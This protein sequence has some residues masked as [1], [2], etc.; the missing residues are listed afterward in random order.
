MSQIARAFCVLV[1]LVGFAQAKP[2][3]TF[4]A[5]SYTPPKGWKTAVKKGTLT[6]QKIDQGKGTFAMILVPPIG[7]SRG[8]LA[9]DFRT[10]WDSIITA[11]FNVTDAPTMTPGTPE[12]GWEAL[13]GSAKGS[14]EG[15]AAMIVLV[16]MTGGGRTMNIVIAMNSDTYAAGVQ[17]FLESVEMKKVSAPAT[18]APATSTPPPAQGTGAPTTTFD[19]GWT[20][21][22]EAN[23]VR[24]TREGATVFLHYPVPMDDASRRDTSAYYWNQLVAPRYAVT[25]TYAQDSTSTGLPVYFIQGDATDRATGKQ[26]FVSLRVIPESGIAHPIEVVTASRAAFTQVFPDHDKLASIRGANRFAI[27]SELVGTWS[28][29]TGTSAQMF[30]TATGG[31][32]GMNAAVS[33]N[34]FVFGANGTFNAEYK[35]ATGMVG[36]MK[37]YQVREKGT[38]TTSPWEL[39]LKKSDGTT[40]VYSAYYEMTRGGYV[41]HLQDKKYTGMTYS[42]G[43]VK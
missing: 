39:T 22:A 27:G 41:L 37:T 42:L 23:W 7:N 25:K 5:M 10:A 28:G 34:K 15:N 16:T 26:V 19:D 9:E 21:T 1:M 20:S 3:P 24:V 18:S 8:S 4:E 32:A 31:Y 17:A 29:S 13:S 6:M 43:R 40:S 12:N 30:Y 33:A 14:V 36:S 35:G 11:G 2:K 38:F